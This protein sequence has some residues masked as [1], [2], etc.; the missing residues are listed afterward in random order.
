MSLYGE[1]SMGLIKNHSD[2]R[3]LR[4]AASIAGSC[5]DALMDAAQPGVSTIA[6]E[7]MANKLLAKNRSTAPFKQ[8]DG[9]GHAICVS[10]ND[11]IINGPPSRERLLKEGDVVS[12]AIGSEYRGMHG[13]AARTKYVGAHPPE[14]IHRLLT[15]TYAVFREIPKQSPSTLNELVG[16]IPELAKQHQLTV[17]EGLSGAG[18]GKKLHDD[19]VIPND[20]TSLPDP[21]PLMPGFA[22]TLMPICSLG[23]QAQYITH[24]DGWTFITADHAM[25]AHFAET[26]L[27]TDNG[28]EILS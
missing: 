16:L 9:F 20:P 24:A 21:Y 12:I 6:L 18:I 4:E 10:V 15:G 3:N 11:E 27:V 1:K 28:I 19:P 23:Q 5:C 26:L 22:F 25:A 7:V 17:I 8:F 13:K 2:L 14:D